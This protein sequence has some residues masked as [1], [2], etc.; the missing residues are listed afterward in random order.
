M[1]SA[2]CRRLPSAGGV[3]SVGVNVGPAAMMPR[4]ESRAAGGA[5]QRF[6]GDQRWST[7]HAP[8]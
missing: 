8:L 6:G 4:G 3:E 2:V 5:T 7:D 1:L